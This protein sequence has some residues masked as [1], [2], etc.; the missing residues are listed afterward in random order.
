MAVGVK[1]TGEIL[2]KG[3]FAV[4]RSNNIKGG[5]FLVNS[6]AERNNIPVN[7]RVSLC[8]CAVRDNGSGNP[9]LYWLKT[10]LNATKAQ[11]ADNQYWELIITDNTFNAGFTPKGPWSAATNTPTLADGVGTV[12]DTYMVSESGTVNFGSGNITF[13]AGNTVIYDGTFW[14]KVNSVLS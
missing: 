7:K 11:L 9:A 13:A 4:G 14:R 5:P 12:G 8:L 10:P 6:L 2:P 1:V 3:D